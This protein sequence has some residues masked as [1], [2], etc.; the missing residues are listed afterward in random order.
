MH[1]PTSTPSALDLLASADPA[2]LGALEAESDPARLTLL[3]GRWQA[4]PRHEARSLLRMYLYT[5]LRRMELLTLEWR[6]VDFDDRCLR[7]PDTKTGRKVT[8]LG[9][10]AVALLEALPKVEGNPYVFPGDVEG[11]HFVALSGPARERISAR[12]LLCRAAM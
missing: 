10:A 3:A 12:R 1:Q 5:G 2:L 8:Y 9:D 6:F 4:D 7:L 11:G